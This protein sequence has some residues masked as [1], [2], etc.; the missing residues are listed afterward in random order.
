MGSAEPSS[1]KGIPAKNTLRRE[2][3]SWDAFVT[4]MKRPPH[5]SHTHRSSTT[6]DSEFSETESFDHAIQLAER[7]WPEGLARIKKSHRQ[8]AAVQGEM[9]ERHAFRYSESG[10]EVD[11][12]RAVEGDPEHMMEF[13]TVHVPSAGRV[14]KVVVNVAASGS[15]GTDQLFTRG[16]AAVMVADLIE[17]SGLRSEIWICEGSD[18]NGSWGIDFR[19][20]LKEPD[21]PLDMDLLAFAC[22]HAAVIRRLFFRAFEQLSSWE[23][24]RYLGGAGYGW[25]REVLFH[26]NSLVISKEIHSGKVTDVEKHVEDTVRQYLES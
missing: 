4:D 16:A 25:P 7:G 14:V 3:Q 5:E 9:T 18:N 10:D 11:V 24:D 22:C 17:A 15:I 2:W 6:R 20:K 23:F 8:L 13:E 19:V 12:G 21:Q 1:L 26:D